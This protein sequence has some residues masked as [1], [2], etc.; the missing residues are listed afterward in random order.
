VVVIFAVANSHTTSTRTCHNIALSQVLRV[1]MDA[2][3]LGFEGELTRAVQVWV[4]ADFECVTSSCGQV[5][6]RVCGCVN[7]CI[8]K[9]ASTILPET[10]T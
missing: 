1:E 5:R 7:L 4:R 9:C 3:L 6:V 10:F 2:V 8:Q